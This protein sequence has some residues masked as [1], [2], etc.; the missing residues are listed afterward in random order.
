MNE[1]A[2]MVK[3]YFRQNKIKQTEIAEELGISKQNL[4]KLLKKKESFNIDDA[5]RLL[6]V[7]NCHIEVKYSIVENKETNKNKD[8]KT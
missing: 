1:L 8:R 6:N 2:R 7:I 4:F 3:E 5:N